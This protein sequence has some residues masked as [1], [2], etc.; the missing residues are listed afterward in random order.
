M[1]HLHRFFSAITLG[2]AALFLALLALRDEMH[3]LP[4]G[5]GDSFG[6][7]AFVE[8]AQQLLDGFSITSFD[9]HALDDGCG[10]ARR[11]MQS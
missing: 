3:L 2:A 10:Q 5:F 6:Y 1:L 8:P 4:V 9:F 11:R 7:Y